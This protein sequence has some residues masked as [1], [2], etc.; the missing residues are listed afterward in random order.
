MRRAAQPLVSVLALLMVVSARAGGTDSRE[1][2][3][4]AHAVTRCTKFAELIS[5]SEALNLK[6]ND[7]DLLVAEADALVQL[8]RPGEAIGVY[9]NALTVG[10]DRE[11][12][13][14]KIVT[15]QSLRHSLLES[16]L[17]HEG[18]F[19]E[20]EC[21]SAWLPGAPDEVTVFK[22]R[23]FLLQGDGQPAAALDAYMAAA[24]LGPKD[25]TVARAIVKLGESTGRK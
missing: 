25:R 23:G 19:A 24:R 13:G 17:T 20:R 18:Q 11:L 5:C 14:A 10:A 1:G 4:L 21:E 3:R 15:A 8:K 7:P 2:G 12:V 16:C 9:R 6:P 22:R